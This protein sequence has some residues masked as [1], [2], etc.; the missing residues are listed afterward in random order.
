MNTQIRSHRFAIVTVI[1]AA[2]CAAAAIGAW[3]NGE[4][5]AMRSGEIA[6]QRSTFVQS[7]GAMADVEP[8]V[9]DA[10]QAPRHG[11]APA[12]HEVVVSTF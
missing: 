10:S 8:G 4:P 12:E 2:A 7:G 3:E 6:A 5:H 11:G 1:A 9:P